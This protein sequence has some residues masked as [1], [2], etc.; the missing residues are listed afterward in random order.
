[1]SEWILEDTS[2]AHAL[3][4]TV[5]R[6]FNVADANPRGR[7][8]QA[9]K[10]ATHWIKVVSEAALG[11]RKFV[12]VS[13][14]DDPTADGTGIRDYIHVKDLAFAQKRALTRLGEADKI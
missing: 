5:L 10:G 2:K 14:T 9:T 6:C 8:G 13:G 11:K 3:K 12:E 7:T 4:H 1:M